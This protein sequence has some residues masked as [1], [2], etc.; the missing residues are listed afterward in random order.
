MPASTR[1]IAE[2]LREFNLATKD[3]PYN[4]TDI[5][6]IMTQLIDSL[7][8]MVKQP[9]PE[10]NEQV[11]AP[12]GGDVEK[13]ARAALKNL[14]SITS[15]PNLNGVQ[16][17]G[18]I[19]QAI[20]LITIFSTHE[21]IRDALLEQRS[22]KAL[23]KAMDS[24]S[25]LPV[26]PLA[27]ECAS[28]CISCACLCLS[29]HI[30][31][32][33]GLRGI[34]EAFSSGI[35]PVLMGCA[36]LLNTEEE[37]YFML[38]CHELPRFIIYPSVLWRVQESLETI[39]VPLQAGQSP[40]SKKAWEAFEQLTLSAGGIKQVKDTG[41]DHGLEGCAN[42]TCNKFY[43]RSELRLC[44]GCKTVY[45]CSKACQTESW[46]TMH[47]ERCMRA[48]KAG[49]D[50]IPSRDL[51]FVHTLAQNELFM[52]SKRIVSICKKHQV[53]KPVVQLD[54]TTRPFGMIIQPLASLAVEY[55]SDELQDYERL[56]ET[57]EHGTGGIHIGIVVRYPTGLHSHMTSSMLYLKPDGNLDDGSSDNE[58][59]YDPYY[60]MRLVVK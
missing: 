45:Y 20:N 8:I 13:V 41:V 34:I 11:I 49:V 39:E 29:N 37:H 23:F 3:E 33:E 6:F 48:R 54:Y 14:Q 58:L 31:A 51:S 44:A 30:F 4:G 21:S 28:I 36:N 12:M 5:G 9:S 22:I 35:L 1:S 17:L 53:T 7:T 26:H 50:P 38:L 55:T 25:P 43:R 56:F 19:A 46:K 16:R 10:W 52:R 40:A 42:S 15:H 18:R 24:L 27:H 57:T 32:H 60:N 47:R 59:M 2:L